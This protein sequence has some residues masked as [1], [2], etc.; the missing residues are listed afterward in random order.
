MKVWPFAKELDVDRS[1]SLISDSWSFFG[2]MARFFFSFLKS[3][4]QTDEFGVVL[5]WLS[6]KN[7]STVN[8]SQVILQFGLVFCANF[9]EMTPT[10]S[11][12]STNLVESE[13][14]DNAEL[15]RMKVGP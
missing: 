8:S 2:G 4:R 15:A 14:D 11:T 5:G 12:N 10:V 1:I 9:L 13:D 7:T 3:S 6:E